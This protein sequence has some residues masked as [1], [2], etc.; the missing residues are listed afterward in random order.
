MQHAGAGKGMRTSPARSSMFQAMVFRIAGLSWPAVSTEVEGA[1]ANPAA[2]G[3]S[4][5]LMTAGDATRSS[6]PSWAQRLL[7]STWAPARIVHQG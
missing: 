5:F 7:A 1:G 6:L 2:R 3:L 4:W